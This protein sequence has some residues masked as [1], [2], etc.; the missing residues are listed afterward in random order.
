MKR[1]LCLLMVMVMLLLSFTLMACDS[2]IVNDDDTT[3]DSGKSDSKEDKEDKEDKVSIPAGYKLYDDGNITFAYPSD[4]SKEEEDGTVL[5]MNAE[6]SANNI[7]VVYE[8]KT[9]MYENMTVESFNETMKPVFDS[10]GM[11]IYNLSISQT[12][13][14]AGIDVTKMS[15]KT[16]VSGVSMQQTVYCT[17]IGEKTYSVTITVVDS[18]SALVKNV[19]DTLDHAK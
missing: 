10:V 2:D 3:S 9:D 19:L 7:T 5:L 17:T 8:P 11:S 14:K 1:F 12:K 4:W 15:F 13:N 16:T 6:E 18:D